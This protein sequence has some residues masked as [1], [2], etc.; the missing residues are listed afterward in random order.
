MSNAH[1][2]RAPTETFVRD[3]TEGEGAGSGTASRSSEREIPIRLTH[4]PASESARQG[5]PIPT[6]VT[7]PLYSSHQQEREPF[8]PQRLLDSPNFAVDTTNNNNNNN[9]HPR[10][11]SATPSPSKLD[12][13]AM[14]DQ[15]PD[16][17]IAGRAGWRNKLARATRFPNALVRE[18]LAEFLGSAILIIFGNGAVAEVVLS[19]K[20]KGGPVNDFF[21]INIAYGLAVAFGVYIAG[22]VSGGHL[23]PA[24][25]LAMACLGKIQWR[26]VPVYFLAQYLGC[27]VGSFIIW[28][29]YYDALFEHDG[30][31]RITDP[32]HINAT[33]GI[34]ASYPQHYLSWSNGLV[35]QIFATSFLLIGIL[36]LTDERN[37]APPKGV[38]PILVGLLVTAIGLSYG[39]NCGYPINPA[40][41]LGPRIFTSI[42]GWGLAPF[43]FRSHGWFWIPVVGP[44]LGALLGVAIYQLFIGNQWPALQ[45]TGIELQVVRK[46][47][48]NDE[49]ELVKSSHLRHGDVTVPVSLS[50][51]DGQRLLEVR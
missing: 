10:S 8:L 4:Q 24:V 38:V 43:N 31:I 12:K 40:R 32:A 25:S 39:Y 42:A 50:T 7:S 48:A 36:A 49:Y 3:G 1:L 13:E 35:D 22:G 33:A 2:D 5:R 26:K 30:G 15:H 20:G 46:G 6:V 17:V 14:A 34:F 45:R 21:S 27:F 44:H 19:T 18:G 11:V 47:G 41:D 16:E 29:I 9:P 51:K 23:N 37:T 28:A